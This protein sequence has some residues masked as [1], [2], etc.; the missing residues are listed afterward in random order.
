MLKF[1]EIQEKTKKGIAD[2]NPHIT[3]IDRYI[4]GK[5]IGTYLVAL[6]LIIG[7][8]IIFDISEKIDDFVDKNAPLKEIIFNYYANFIPYFMNMFSPMFV[9]ITVI[10]F[11]SKLAANSEIIAMLAGGI[12]FKR[13]MY[14]YFLSSAFI[15]V[16]SL[17]LNLY[18]IPPC[19]MGRLGFEAKYIKKPFENTNRNMHYQIKPGTFMYVQSFST[20]NNTAYQ[21][22]L[23]TIKGHD[24]ISKL[25]ANEAQW[26]STKN[27][28]S[29]KDYYLRQY[30]GNKESV[31]IGSQTDTTLSITIDDF[32][33]KK[34][35]VQALGYG[36]LNKLI[37]AQKMRG[38]QMVEYG[39]IERNTRWAFPFSA[40]ILTL[41]GVSISSKK[42]RGGI[43]MNIGIGIALS[44]SYILFMRFSQMFVFTGTLPPFFAIW[45]PNFIFAVIA[46][47][48]Y[49]IAPK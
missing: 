13:L 6:L 49:R 34:N 12:S 7:I 2:F 27:C 42:R 11:T 9:F 28:W 20:F 41:I 3:T 40:F 1:K 10:F 33:R 8:V 46:V 38:D 19:N 23:E 32:Y 37:K 35:T 21:F 14:P 43:G 26:D 25:S 36:R 31:T 24:I 17:L 22:T 45:L 44:F 47:F 15:A 16:F 30:D 29:L 48:L 4:I 18:I 39:L 5:F